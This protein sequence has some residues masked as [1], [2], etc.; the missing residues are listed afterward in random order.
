MVAA[1]GLLTA[2]CAATPPPER[3]RIDPALAAALS[4]LSHPQAALRF[5]A[6]GS[7][8]LGVPDGALLNGLSADD[9]TL[10]LGPP[11]RVR[12]DPPAQ[13]WQYDRPRCIVDV[14]LYADPPPPL[15]VY[16][17]ERTRLVK[18]VPPGA[19]LGEVWGARPQSGP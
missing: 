9:L 18:K 12:H 13:V 6:P 8:N 16:V 2:A 19:C 7:R 15:V 17:Q 14:F 10:V 4:A 1:A 11:S 3:P 5:D